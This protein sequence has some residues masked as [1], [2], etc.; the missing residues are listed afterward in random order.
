MF[1]YCTTPGSYAAVAAVHHVHEAVLRIA[2]LPA[3]RLVFRV[4]LHS[5]FE[6]DVGRHLVIGPPWIRRA[7]GK[8]SQGSLCSFASPD[9]SGFAQTALTASS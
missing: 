4:A 6:H 3:H 1:A 5:A 9:R 8:L 7:I 2:G